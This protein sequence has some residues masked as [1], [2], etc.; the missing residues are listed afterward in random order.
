MY[1]YQ[2]EELGLP[3]VQDLPDDARRDPI[4]VRSEHAEHGRDGSRIPLPWTAAGTTSGFSAEGSETPSWLPQPDWFGGYAAELQERDADSTLAFY[5][6]ALLARRSFAA[7]EPLR[8]LDSGREDV[9]AF[10]RGALTCVA[11]FDGEAFVPQADWGT[12][13]CHSR[14]CSGPLAAATTAWLQA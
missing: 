2:G 4:W 8:W 7:G 13:V 10:R 6:R 3:E 11:V 12:V 9:I 5:R 1:L 14:R